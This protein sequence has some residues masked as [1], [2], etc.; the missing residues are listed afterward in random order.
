MSDTTL[1]SG[2]GVPGADVPI[3]VAATLLDTVPKLLLK[4]LLTPYQY[5][6]SLTIAL[7]KSTGIGALIP[8]LTQFMP[9]LDTQTR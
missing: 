3:T 7:T 1:L 9:S 8:K 6:P 4:N 2:S 5:V